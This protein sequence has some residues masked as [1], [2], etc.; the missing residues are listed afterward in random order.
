MFRKN[1]KH[2]QVGLF[3]YDHLLGSS[4]GA[5]KNTPGYYFHHI[6]FKQLN[7]EIFAPLYSDKKS[8]PNS[9]HQQH[10]ECLA[11]ATTT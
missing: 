5:F 6:I 8:A 10:G 4:Y 1:E 7:E 11:V 9:P 3:G 2:R